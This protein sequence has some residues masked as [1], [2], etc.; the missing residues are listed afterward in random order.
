MRT[1]SC[2]FKCH[3]SITSVIQCQHFFTSASV[4]W[5]WHPH[6]CKCYSARSL[7]IL[8]VTS[9]YSQKS[10]GIKTRRWAFDIHTYTRSYNVVIELLWDEHKVAI[11]KVLCYD[12]DNG[13]YYISSFSLTCEPFFVLVFKRMSS[14]LYRINES[15]FQINFVESLHT[16]KNK[17][18][19][20]D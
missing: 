11:N 17:I 4:I 8:L 20:F 18:A 5:C 3:R 10:R 6:Q 19:Y 1:E 16:F 2:E 14:S 7:H 13:C 12:I 9:S 15:F